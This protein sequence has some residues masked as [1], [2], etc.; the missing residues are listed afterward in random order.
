MAL[1]DG[2]LIVPFTERHITPEY[3]SWLNDPAL[4]RYSEQRH[5]YHDGDSCLEY[6]QGRWMR[7]VINGDMVGTVAADID[8]PNGVADLGIL[9][10]KPGNG[11][12][13]WKLALGELSGYRMITAGCMEC[14]VPMLK[15]LHRTMRYSHRIRGRFLFESK[16]MDGIYYVR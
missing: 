16:P 11:L 3:L 9:I 7:A 5:V 8:T 14:N 12:A 6:A 2:P 15:I 1:A 4:M 10:G 13:A